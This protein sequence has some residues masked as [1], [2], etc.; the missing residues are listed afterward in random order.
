MK[1]ID[2]DDLIPWVVGIIAIM[3]VIFVFAAAIKE[4]FF[5]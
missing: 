5:Q 1:K 2:I 3:F 4:V